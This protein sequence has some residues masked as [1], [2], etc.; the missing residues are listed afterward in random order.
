MGAVLSIVQYIK[1]KI[2]EFLLNLFFEKIAPILVKFFIIL[3]NEK[4]EAWIL[5]LTEAIACLPNFKFSK[6][7]TEIDDVNYADIT[8]EGD[9]P[10]SSETC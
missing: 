8:Q 6:V 3:L 7:L 10:E 4:L 5:L 1:D 2:I 9:V